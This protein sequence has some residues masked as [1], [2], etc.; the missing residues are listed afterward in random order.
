MISGIYDSIYMNKLTNSGDIISHVR[1][2]SLVDSCGVPGFLCSIRVQF[3]K[4]H[5]RLE[6][7]EVIIEPFHEKILP[8][9]KIS[10]ELH[11][12]EGTKE[13]CERIERSARKISGGI[14]ILQ[15]LSGATLFGLKGAKSVLGDITLAHGGAIR[16]GGT[17]AGRG[18]GHCENEGWQKQ[19][20]MHE[21][22]L[23][24]EGPEM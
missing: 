1:R 23:G 5:I 16:N 7:I 22:K 24:G 13:A 9:R 4:Y 11:S 14:Q 15:T 6:H 20:V 10:G 21:T 18:C 17:P 8:A 12:S 3:K 19:T 2:G